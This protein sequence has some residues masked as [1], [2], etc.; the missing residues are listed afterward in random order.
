MADLSPLEVLRETWRARWPEAMALWSRYTR[1]SDPRW[2]L[3]D[4]A[5]SA[6]GLTESFA[7]IR[8][9]D[10]AVVINLHQALALGVDRFALEILAHEVG[11]HMYAPATVN[12][13]ARLIARVRRALPG[14]EREAPFIA[15]LYEDLLINDRLHRARALDLPGVFLQ[16]EASNRKKGGQ[17]K[18]SRLWTLYMRIYEI[19]WG[20]TRASMAT[21]LNSADAVLEG[22]AHLGARLVRVYAR[23]WLTGGGRFAALCYPYVNEDGAAQMRTLLRGWIDAESPAEG[24]DLPTGLVEIEADEATAIM[25]PSADPALSGL[26]EDDE[27][28]KTEDDERKTG[29]RPMKQKHGQPLAAKKDGADKRGGQTRLPFEF[30][31]ILKALGM[32]LDDHDIAVHYYRERARPHLVPFPT[33]KQPESDEPQVEGLE[34]WDIGSSLDDVDWLE[35]VMVSPQVIPGITTRQRTYGRMAGVEPKREPLDLDIYVDCSGSMPNPQQ[36]VSFLALAGA[37]MCLSALRAGAR[38]QATLWSGPGQFDKTPGFITDEKAILRVLT[39]YICGG[40]AFPLHVLVDTYGERA[41]TPRQRKTHLMV[42]SD[43]GVDTMLSPDERGVSGAS[44]ARMAL[45]RGGGGGTLLLN[46]YQDWKGNP[47][48][49]QLVEMGF[50]IFVVRSWEDLVGFAR[51]FSKKNYADDRVNR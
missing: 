24:A 43:D 44:I 21:G 23:D 25:H 7:M 18:P 26:A 42:I 45:D 51:A 32:P 39:G 8:L 41:R 48:L 35:S 28:D 13:C 20:K 31:A 2:C 12:E 46:L 9:R 38:V 17:E 14:H 11:H 1:L 34:P 6:E 29:A 22:D 33:R 40:T 49:V 4:A 27:A 5:A 10:Q 3:T 47:S 30:G 36:E 37:I 50:D 19:L 15:N 16:L